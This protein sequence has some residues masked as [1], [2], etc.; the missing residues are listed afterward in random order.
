MDDKGRVYFGASDKEVPQEDQE[1]LEE[2]REKLRDSIG[3]QSGE[4]FYCRTLRLNRT[5][6]DEPPWI[7]EG[8]DLDQPFQEE[9]DSA[10]GPGEQEA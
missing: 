2:T 5:P 10:R 3:E 9:E 1:R 7:P 8:S 6:D 4:R